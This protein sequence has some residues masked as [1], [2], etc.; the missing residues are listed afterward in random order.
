MTERNSTEHDQPDIQ[1][2]IKGFQ[3]ASGRLPDG[4]LWWKVLAES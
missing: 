4:L 2:T 3:A 1:A